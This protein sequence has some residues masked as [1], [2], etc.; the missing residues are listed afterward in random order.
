VIPEI[1]EY[2]WWIYAVWLSVFMLVA[3]YR[4]SSKEP[5]VDFDQDEVDVDQT[6]PG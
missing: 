3:I 5:E 2:N 4:Q 1:N 6:W